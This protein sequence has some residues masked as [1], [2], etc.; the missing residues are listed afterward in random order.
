[1]G[2]AIVVMSFSA[3]L[4]ALMEV[5]VMSLFIWVLREVFILFMSG[6]WAFGGLHAR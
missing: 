6:L 4:F 2:D 3:V 1:M 5:L